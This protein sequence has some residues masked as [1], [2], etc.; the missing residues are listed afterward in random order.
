MWRLGWPR[1]CR[2]WVGNSR[3]AFP[4]EGPALLL[5]PNVGIGPPHWWTQTAGRCPIRSTDTYSRERG[6]RDMFSHGSSQP[7][8]AQV[9][10]NGDALLIVLDKPFEQRSGRARQRSSGATPVRTLGAHRLRTLRSSDLGLLRGRGPPPSDLWSKG[11]DDR[12]GCA[13]G[14]SY[15]LIPP[16]PTS[17]KAHQP[18]C[19]QRRCPRRTA[20]VGWAQACNEGSLRVVIR[21]RDV[22]RRAAGK[23]QQTRLLQKAAME[24]LQAGRFVSP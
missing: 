17:V 6:V 19:C 11:C 23:C 24:L 20:P 10:L 3:A 7:R 18:A 2:C 4:T 13:A 8:A 9:Q 12:A 22:R 1:R 5:R 14:I 16:Q 15:S 21:H